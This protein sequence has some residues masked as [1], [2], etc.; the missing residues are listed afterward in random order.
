VYIRKLAHTTEIPLTLSGEEGKDILLAITKSVLHN[1][2]V[3][4]EKIPEY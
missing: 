4:K 2:M 1:F 3:L